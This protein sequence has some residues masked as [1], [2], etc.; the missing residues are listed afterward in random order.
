MLGP[1]GMHWR[2]CS[3]GVC[4]TWS[5]HIAS[6]FDQ[7]FLLLSWTKWKVG[8]GAVH[9]ERTHTFAV[10]NARLRDVCSMFSSFRVVLWVLDF[11]SMDIFGWLQNHFS[12]PGRDVCSWYLSMQRIRRTSVT[13]Q[14]RNENMEAM[15]HN[16]LFRRYYKKLEKENE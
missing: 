6:I 16:F 7:H 11:S 15:K 14:R 13:D 12:G 3:A 10:D 9:A 8:D 5:A 2:R 4:T 1:R